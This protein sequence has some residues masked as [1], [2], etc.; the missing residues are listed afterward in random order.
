[1]ETLLRTQTNFDNLEDEDPQVKFALLSESANFC[2]R[3]C[4]IL[5]IHS[6]KIWDCVLGPDLGTP[7]SN[8]NLKPI[9]I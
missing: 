2:S 7:N 8:P 3:C 5:C 9:S 4:L 1:M 6:Q